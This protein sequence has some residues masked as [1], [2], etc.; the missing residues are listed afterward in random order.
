LALH[1]K[2]I[3][4]DTTALTTDW[5]AAQYWDA[6]EDLAQLMTDLIGPVDLPSYSV[7]A[8][9]VDDINDFLSGLLHGMI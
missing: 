7:E 9:D 1:H 8:V 4:A 5:D 6:G 3:S 2:A